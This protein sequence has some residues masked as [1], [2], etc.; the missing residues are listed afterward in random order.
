MRCG[1]PQIYPCNVPSRQSDTVPIGVYIGKSNVSTSIMLKQVT[2]E[3]AVNII[4]L[5][6][7]LTFCWP[8][9]ANNSSK[10][11]IIGYKIVQICAVISVCLLLLPSVYPIYL[12][13]DDM[14]VISKSVSQL[15]CEAQC[16]IQTVI[17]YCKH[18][19]LQVSF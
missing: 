2:P 9:S 15:I 3:K 1:S 6:V 4:W 10:I 7:A 5:S 19:T 8:L 12:C 16:I 18:E 13:P 14:E 17:C 11:R